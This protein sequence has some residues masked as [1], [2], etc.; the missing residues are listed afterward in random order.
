LGSKNRNLLTLLD[1]VG[2]SKDEFGALKARQIIARGE[3]SEASVTP[4]HLAKLMRAL[5]GRK[6]F[7][8]PFQGLDQSLT[9]PGVTLAALASP[10]AI[11]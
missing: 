3:A 11:V 5:K 8:A 10:L 9:L 7:L 2:G 1:F 6:M 4:G